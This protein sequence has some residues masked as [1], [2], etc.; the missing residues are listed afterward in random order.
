MKTIKKAMLALI[1]AALVSGCSDPPPAPADN[2]KINVVTTIFAPYD[3]VREIAGDSVNLK[4]LLP[5]AAETHSFD[6]S[7]KDIKDIKNADIF[8]YVGGESD[9]WVRDILASTDTSDM[10]VISLTELV[11]T[12]E[13][14]HVE[15]MQVDEH[16]S[17]EEKD[18]DEH[19]W[20]S[21]K[22]AIKIVD[23][24]YSALVNADPANAERYTARRGEYT[25][26]LEKLDRK[27][28]DLMAGASRRTIVVGDRFALR[29]FADAYGL[30][31]YAAF[32]GCSTESKASIKTITF[33]IDK[34]ADEHIPVVFYAE[35]SNQETADTIVEGS[36]AKKLLLH[37]VHNVSKDEFESGVGYLG[38]ME[39]NLENLRE[40][41]N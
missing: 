38:L 18:L 1:L 11:E 4:M 13:E 25:A 35:L 34:V 12:V 14:E 20:T 8:I 2:E 23:G 24:I 15:G 29:Y 9:D 31:Y 5:P 36:D 30:E 19:V 33:L 10:T 27:F 41:L 21:P 17:E 28:E 39:Q 3:F 26:E 7:P 40:A 6:P 16:E 22:N 37:A 32:P